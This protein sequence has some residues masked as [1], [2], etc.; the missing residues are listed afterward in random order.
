[1]QY[2]MQILMFTLKLLY[3]RYELKMTIFEMYYMNDFKWNSNDLYNA[4]MQEK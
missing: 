2:L 1:M 4:N 3:V